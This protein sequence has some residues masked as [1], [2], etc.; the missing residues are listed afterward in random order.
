MAEP[1][2]SVVVPAYN[3]SWCIRDVVRSVQWQTRRDWEMILV[4]DGSTDDTWAVMQ[5]LAAGDERISPLHFDNGGTPVAI[6]RGLKAARGQWLAVV[7]ADDQWYSSMLE[8]CMDFLAEHPGL[9][10]VYTPMVPVT[11][12][13][14]VIQ[15]HSKPCHSG[16]LTEK[17]FQS[18]FIHDSSAIFHRRV[19]ETC[20]GFDETMRVGSGHE[21]WLRVSTKF[22]F[23]LIDEPLAQRTWTPTSLTRSNRGRG[24]QFTTDMLERFY[25]Q[26]G[27]KDILKAGP[28]LRRLSHVSYKA[29]KLLLA[30]GNPRQ[31]KRYLA[32]AV[33]YR[34]TN[35][36]AWPGLLASAVASL[37]AGRERKDK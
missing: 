12:D 10:I 29:G 8:R 7:G 35:L 36:R 11:R 37:F 27:G 23:G 28:A 3:A 2:M 31:A 20:G 33:K 15:G 16:W 19:Y 13:N 21:F 6:N 24:R 17:L 25:F 32:K 34:P 26:K 9:S 30:E 4:D 18:I 1:N 5:E 22:E 14:Q